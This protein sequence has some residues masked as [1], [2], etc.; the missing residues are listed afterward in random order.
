MHSRR[1]SIPVSGLQDQRFFLASSAS[2]GKY[3]A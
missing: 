3:K 2:V 1:E